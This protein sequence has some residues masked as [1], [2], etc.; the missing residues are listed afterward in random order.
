M[1][2]QSGTS[3][4]RS[5][6]HYRGRTRQS[7][8]DSRDEDEI[9]IKIPFKKL[10]AGFNVTA[11]SLFPS[12]EIPGIEVKDNDIFLDTGSAAPP[13]HIRGQLTSVRIASILTSSRSTATLRKM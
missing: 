2:A 9:L 4:H 7:H 5:N 8:S 1:L 3:A 10:L 12:T 6:F 11:A 13:P